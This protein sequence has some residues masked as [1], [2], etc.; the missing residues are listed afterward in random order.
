MFNLRGSDQG[1]SPYFTSHAII[2]PTEN[3]LFAGTE[4]ITD[5]I[6]AHVSSE[7]TT[8]IYKPYGNDEMTRAIKD[9][10]SKTTGKILVPVEANAG[11]HNLIPTNRYINDYSPIEALRS[12]K[13]TVE[14]EGMVA[15]N[16]R[17]SVAVIKYLHWLE[18]NVNEINITEIS[19]AAK[20]LE[21][22][23]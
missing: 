18:N 5:E 19:G 22:R 9:I 20:L 3:I 13:N 21:F 7:G 1:N 6:K 8:L 10:L 4:R 11:I 16:K 14:A 23:K 15:A 17:D 2:T 12:V